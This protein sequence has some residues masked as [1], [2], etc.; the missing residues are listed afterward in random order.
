MSEKERVEQEREE[1][2]CAWPAVVQDD[3]INKEINVC[4]LGHEYYI[5]AVS[6][7]VQCLEHLVS[8]TGT[9]VARKQQLPTTKSQ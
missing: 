3:E 6:G 9:F 8:S 7:E 4:L 2:L 5:R 1:M